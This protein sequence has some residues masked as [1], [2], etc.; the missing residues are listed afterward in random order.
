MNE[1]RFV[2][3]KIFLYIYLASWWWDYCRLFKKV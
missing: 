1:Y 2:F 3:V